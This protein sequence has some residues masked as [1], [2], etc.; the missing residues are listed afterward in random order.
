M[1][2]RLAQGAF[3]TRGGN[4]GPNSTQLSLASHG[5]IHVVPL[6]YLLA[7]IFSE[8][9]EDLLLKPQCFLCNPNQNCL[10]TTRKWG[11][12]QLVANQLKEGNFQTLL[13]WGNST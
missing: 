8:Q 2:E 12:P 4:A 9:F 13:K 6:E 11:Y 3:F 5:S 1:P 7:S 10:K